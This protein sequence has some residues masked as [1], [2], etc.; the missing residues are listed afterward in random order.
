MPKGGKIKKGEN[1]LISSITIKEKIIYT[2]KLIDILLSPRQYCEWDNKPD[3]VVTSS[4]GYLL[5]AA[6]DYCILLML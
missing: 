4:S 5:H 1:I 2:L 3:K 6:G